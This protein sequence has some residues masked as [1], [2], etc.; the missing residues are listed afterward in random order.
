MANSSSKS[1]ASPWAE[2]KPPLQLTSISKNLTL[3][4]ISAYKKRKN[5]RN[6]LTKNQFQDPDTPE[7]L[8]DTLIITL[9]LNPPAQNI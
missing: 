7:H 3:R 2:N 9:Q 6:I 4:I 1:A 5:L 8:L